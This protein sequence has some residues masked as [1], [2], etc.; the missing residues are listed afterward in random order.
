LPLSALLWR[1]PVVVAAL[2]VAW[3]LPRYHRWCLAVVMLTAIAMDGLL[4]AERPVREIT[5]E[6]EARAVVIQQKLAALADDQSLRRILGA[7][8]AEAKPEAL[9]ALLDQATRGLGGQLDAL[10]LVDDRGL[11]VAWTG[12]RPRLPLRLRPLGERAIQTEPGVDVYWL[13]WRE[14][15]SDDGRTQGALLAG[16]R[17]A[18]P[19]QRQILGVSAG[20]AAVILPRLETPP[21]SVVLGNLGVEIG[22]A[23]PRLWST[24]GTALLATA[25][26]VAAVGGTTALAGSGIA[27]LAVLPALGWLPHGWWLVGA[28]CAAA[29]GCSRLRAR[30][31][32]RI[33][34]I[35]AIGV[36]AWLLP[37]LLEV[38]GMGTLSQA[39][40]WPGALAAA[41]LAALTAMLRSA[42]VY[43]TRPWAVRLVALTPLLVGAGLADTRLVGLGTVLVLLFGAARGSV[44]LPAVTAAAMLAGAGDA[45]RRTGLLA[46]TEVTLAHMER[47]EAPARL[48]LA[49]LPEPGLDELVRLPEEERLVVL[50]RLAH[51]LALEERVRGGSLSLTDPSGREAGTWGEQQTFVGPAP[52]QLATRALRRGWQISLLDPAPPDDL[53]AALRA[54][55]V[56][57]PV[58][59]FDRSGKPLSRGAAFRPLSPELVGRALAAGRS[60]G[61]VGVGEREFT[62]YLR[63]HGDQ[64]LAVPWLR[65]PLAE[66]ALSLAALTLWAL[67]P[68]TLWLQRRRWRRWWR[69]RRTFGGR[70]RLLSV[71]AAL[72]PVLLL[73]Q[74]LPQQWER[75]R[76]KA[77]L[78][79]A[80]AVGQL[81]INAHR[82]DELGWLVREM[83]GTVVAFR[84]GQL[85]S[86]TRPDLAQLGAVPLLPP[87]EAYERAVRG[88]PEPVVSGTDSISVWV[89]LPGS[90]TTGIVG[91]VDLKLQALGRSPTPGEWFAITG[92]LAMLLALATAERLGQRLSQPLRRLVMAARRLRRGDRLATLDTGGDEDVKALGS[93]FLVMAREVQRREEDL[94]RERDLLERVLTTLSAAVMVAKSDGELE[95]ANPAARQLLPEPFVRLDALDRRFGRDLVRLVDRARDGER[96]E[97]TLNPP[98]TPES[99]WRIAALPLPASS[100]SVLLVLEDLS[101][102]A[103]A[104]RLASL[105]GLARIVAHEVKNPLT[106]IRLWA[107]ELQAALANGAESVVRVAALA[108]PQILERVEH[109]KEVAQGFGNLVALEQWRA[110]PVALRALATDVVTEY[111]VLAQRSISTR[112]VGEDLVIVA[113]PRW[114]QRALRHLLENSARVLAGRPGEITVSV[115]QRSGQAVL[116]VCD[117]GGGVPRELLGRLFEP[118]FSTTSEGTGLGLAVVRRVAELAGGSAEAD[119]AAGGLEVRLFFPIPEDGKR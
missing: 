119:N 89:P 67:A 5:S 22:P 18:E 84:G 87:R 60:W 41:L 61:R 100:G 45:S 81:L 109:L 49:A 96:S 107:E 34:A 30:S 65:P 90:E 29:L 70:L 112:V 72:L 80:R 86:S 93:A 91:V 77:R 35:S 104:Q 106:P 85:A 57:A 62:A 98:G 79:L 38:T 88:W 56:D 117:S 40:L 44:L 32:A 51:W 13:W 17:L 76:A 64:V 53:L 3:R 103:R 94:R 8:G 28:A 95:L 115:S 10:L 108:A 42:A 105:A 69:E 48:L 1:V 19:G 26:V 21:S 55:G 36:A 7:G 52:K 2:A 31:P 39:L 25:I 15:I 58:A 102:V 27:A 11:P 78:E 101:E 68:L 111:S 113:D 47:N 54:A 75:Q 33:L 20:R 24:P 16:V 6:L 82:T 118:H 114:L 50:G 43:T 23:R 14:P 9:F 4:P 73:G 12:P 99:L 83:G 46:T 63:A 37:G 92:V 66:Q 116:A 110:E 97:T 74:L 71:A 59:A